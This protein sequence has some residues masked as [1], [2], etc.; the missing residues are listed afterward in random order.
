MGRGKRPSPKKLGKKLLAIRTQLGLTQIEM[1]DELKK[2]ARS[3]TIYP[4]HVS[5]FERGER[6]PSLLILL[7]YA[8]L[9]GV[10][11]DVLIDDRLHLGD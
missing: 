6:E 5:E 3:T 9:G 2:R 7:A 8:R 1:A 10:S 4:G 11:T